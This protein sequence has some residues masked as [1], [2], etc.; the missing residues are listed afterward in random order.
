M[1]REEALLLERSLEEALAPLHPAD[2]D[3]PDDGSLAAEAWALCAELGWDHA[4][5]PEDLGGMGDDVGPLVILAQAA[6]RHPLAMPLVETA[7]ARWAL[8]TAG[9]EQPPEGA[10]LT[11]AHDGD[12][13]ALR[14]APGG[15][16]ATGRLAR[17]PWARH[18]RA[19]VAAGPDGA[20]VVVDL[21][22][23][24]AA[25]EP[26]VDLA[27]QARDDVVLDAV[28]VAAADGSE[29]RRAAALLAPR[30]EVLRS[31]QI[32]GALGR[33]LALTREHTSRRSQFGRPL[34][35]FQLV[36]AHLATMAAHAALVDAMLDDACRAEDDAA[37][38]A[39][40]GSLALIAAEAATEVARSA[41]Q[42][43]GAIGAT[44][45][46]QLHHFTR[47]LWSWRSDGGGER[48]RARTL[49]E[50]AQAASAAELWAGTEPSPL[51]G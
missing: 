50:R 5:L 31:A 18:A 3:P 6:G 29:G 30:A 1:T 4:G 26:H 16:E 9:L 37:L 40:A 48:R 34:T 19:L 8:A 15:P 32:A 22:G 17:V 12:A 21:E 42:C 36:G 13:L 45:E 47:R 38:A 25:V 44:R 33:A 49:G 11:V 2:W 51:R 23:P 28:A 39:S 46:Y 14:P 24:G 41:H 43:H 10:I 35:R 7:L 20:L 27:G